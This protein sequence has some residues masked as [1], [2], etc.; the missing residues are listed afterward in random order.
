MLYFL[1]IMLTAR[2][3]RLLLALSI[4][5]AIAV[6]VVVAMNRVP[7]SESTLPAAS[8]PVENQAELTLRG[9]SVNETSDGSTKWNLVAATAQYYKDRAQARLSDVKLTTWSPDKKIGEL[10][11]TAPVAIYHNETRDIYLSGGVLARNNK[12]MEFRSQSIRFAG[13]KA[14]LTTADPVR[15]SDSELTLEGTGMMYDVERAA[16]KVHKNVTATITG[17]KHH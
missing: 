15:F 17:G 6:L 4:V 1:R 11:L 13:S 12:G 16:L 2:N 7:S 3:I 9:I 10:V 5:S 14:L 8:G